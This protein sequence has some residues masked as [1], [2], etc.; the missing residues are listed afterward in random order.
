MGCRSHQSLPGPVFST[1]L[2][3]RFFPST[4]QNHS[5]RKAMQTCCLPPTKGREWSGIR[6]HPDWG[7]C[8]LI[9]VRAFP[10]IW[11]SNFFGAP[12]AKL[13]HSPPQEFCWSSENEILRKQI[14]GPRKLRGLAD[15][16]CAV[17]L[18][19]LNV[20]PG[21]RSKASSPN[22]VNGPRRTRLATHGSDHKTQAACRKYTW[23]ASDALPAASQSPLHLP[24]NY[25][26]C[27]H[28]KHL[29]RK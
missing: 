29:S 10:R 7:F 15:E 28:E 26:G 6:V 14:K 21:F 16:C 19:F 24:V 20:D 18:F 4:K 12:G 25:G 13:Q 9:W 23:H 8:F 2:A 27:L 1:K 5:R 11:M 22:P 3:C 17:F